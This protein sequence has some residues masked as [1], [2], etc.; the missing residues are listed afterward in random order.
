MMIDAIKNRLPVDL[1]VGSKLVSYLRKAGFKDVSSQ[2]DVI[3]LTGENATIEREMNL[4]RITQSM[5]S[6]ISAFGNQALAEDF[7]STY[8]TESERPDTTFKFL[9]MKVIGYKNKSSSF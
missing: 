5:P 7:F 4:Q 3:N 8:S 2:I 1:Y 9:K 6:L